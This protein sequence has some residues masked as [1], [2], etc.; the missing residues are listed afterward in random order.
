MFIGTVNFLISWIVFFS[1][2]NRKKFPLYM[3]TG[4]MGVTLAL[5]TDLLMYIY[6]LWY[7]PGTK[8][9]LFCIQLL[10]GFGIYFVT[11]YFFLQSIPKKQT[12]LSMTLHILNW[13]IFVIILEL[14]Y[15]YFGFIKYGLWWNI[16]FSYVADWILFIVF[17]FHHKWVSK[18]LIINDHSK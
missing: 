7:Y 4:Y 6:P 8:I 11:I 14:I 1:F 13:S 18:N 16:G 17:Y 10:N 2:S 15:L 12:V 3:V 9:E 5:I